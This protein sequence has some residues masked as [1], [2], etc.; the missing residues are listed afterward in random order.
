MDYYIYPFDLHTFQNFQDD[1]AFDLI[2]RNDEFIVV[3]DPISGWIEQERRNQVMLVPNVGEIL[4]L[5]KHGR[6]DREL[7]VWLIAHELRLPHPRRIYF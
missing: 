1:P 7:T 6:A 4:V 5:A 2:R 3:T